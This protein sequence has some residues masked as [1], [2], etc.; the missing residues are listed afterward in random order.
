LFPLQQI[1]YTEA[2]HKGGNVVDKEPEDS[3]VL[4]AQKYKSKPNK[5][6]KILVL[7]IVLI[8][9]ALLIWLWYACN[10][11]ENDLQKQNKDL[12]EQ[13]QDLRKELQDE[14]K[15]AHTNSDEASEG[16]TCP[17]VSDS[18][19]A[20][21]RDTVDS[22]NY[23][24]LQASMTDPI[25]VVYAATEFGGPK[26]PVEAVTALDYLSNGTAPWDFNL[27][28]ATIAGYADGDYAQ[29]FSDGV[30]VGRASDGMVVSFDF[31]CGQINQIFISVQEE[32]L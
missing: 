29:Y 23:A 10:K 2:K 24:A 3:S 22:E 5:R 1:P 12:K 15:K 27:P 4:P 7:L 20:N 17:A 25:T 19:K 21:I 8:L 31:E 13:V 6:K 18:L 9:V 14:K 16:D 30:Y 28:A 11:K 26:T 32:I